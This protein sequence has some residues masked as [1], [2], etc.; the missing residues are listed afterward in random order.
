MFFLILLAIIV[1]VIGVIWTL[2]EEKPSKTKK[3]SVSS[4]PS[5]ATEPIDT[6]AE[7]DVVVE[8]EPV[9]DELP[10]MD[11][12]IDSPET[13]PEPVEIVPLSIRIS[14]SSP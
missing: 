6:P 9:V 10:A 12:E 4:T 3:Q 7:P 5:P 13:E 2:N 14:A 8:P 1:I 11:A